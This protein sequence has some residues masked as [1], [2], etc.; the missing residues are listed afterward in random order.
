MNLKRYEKRWANGFWRV[1]DTYE[2]T[3]HSIYGTEK[4][5]NRALGIGN[6]KQ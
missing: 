5:C 4:E 6:N 1:F 3:T 2:Y